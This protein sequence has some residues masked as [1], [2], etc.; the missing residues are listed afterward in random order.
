MLFAPSF[1]SLTMKN[2]ADLCR[3]LSESSLSCALLFIMTSS[4]PC[5]FLARPGRRTY[6]QMAHYPSGFKETA[7]LGKGCYSVLFPRAGIT[8]ASSCH[9]RNVGVLAVSCKIKVSA[10]TAPLSASP[11]SPSCARTHWPIA[12]KFKKA[13]EVP[14][15]PT[16]L[17]LCGK[18][19]RR[20][21]PDQPVH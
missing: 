3:H 1:R 15:I 13:E 2:K 6:P 19:Q 8:P 12:T 17:Q 16:S 4:A 14:E 7:G 18:R 21:A 10:P 5:R 11:S 9:P 20:E